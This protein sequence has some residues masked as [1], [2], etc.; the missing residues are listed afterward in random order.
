[1]KNIK[2]IIAI[3]FMIVGFS[4]C[5]TY[6]DPENYIDHSDAYPMCGEYY[7]L[8]YD[9]LTGDTLLD[10]DGDPGTP[11]L[12]YI[13]NKSYNP[14]HD[15]IWLDNDSYHPATQGY[16]YEYRIKCKADMTTLSFNCAE[17]GYIPVGQVNAPANPIAKI[18]ITESQLILNN[19][20]V[21]DSI[22]FKFTYFDSDGIE[23]GTFVTAGHR[24]TGWENP[25]YDDDM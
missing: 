15:S 11:Y 12:F 10:A 13:Y 22:Y 4:S 23:V 18:T 6:P 20:P 14:T 2:I 16:E 5:E 9:A 17:Q 19:W 21:P 1:M 7:V 25:N 8:D 24:K 3:L